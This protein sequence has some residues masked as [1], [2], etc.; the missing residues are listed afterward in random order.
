MVITEGNSSLRN[1]ILQERYRPAKKL[2]SRDPNIPVCNKS[3]PQGSVLGPLQ[4]SLPRKV[5]R[6]H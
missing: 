6:G 4:I 2:I 3:H 5:A 1:V